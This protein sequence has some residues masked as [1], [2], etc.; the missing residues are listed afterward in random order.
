[1]FILQI[2][3]QFFLIFKYKKGAIYKKQ[4]LFKKKKKNYQ[5]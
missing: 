5:R 2:K 3:K 1:M 4:R